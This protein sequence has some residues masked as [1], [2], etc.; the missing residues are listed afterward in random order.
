MKLAAKFTIGGREYSLLLD[1][2]KAHEDGGL[3]V[4]ALRDEGKIIEITAWKGADGYEANGMAEIYAS[5][6]DYA[7]EA[8]EDC[9]NI[10]LL[11]VGV[12][13]MG[14][15]ANAD[16]PG[17]VVTHYI[18]RDYQRMF[19]ERDGLLAKVR[20]MGERLAKA[21][22]QADHYKRMADAAR[23]KLRDARERL[24]NMASL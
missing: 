7:E 21:E 6:E 20:E 5:D 17:E 19:G 9:K 14:Q 8:V 23:A 13:W 4:W 11:P 12:R 2:R 15:Q 1:T 22:R 24:A 3:A 10:T 16:V 18:V